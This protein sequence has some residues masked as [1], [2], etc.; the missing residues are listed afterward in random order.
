MSYNIDEWK[1]YACTL[2]I[3]I[4]TLEET[5]DE[6]DFSRPGPD[7]GVLIVAQTTAE[8]GEI[9]GTLRNGIVTIDTIIHVSEGSGS[10]IDDLEELLTSTKGTYRAVLIWEGGDGISLLKVDDGVVSNETLDIVTVVQ[11]WEARR[12]VTKGEIEV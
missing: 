4:D 12:K 10:S 8:N 1:Q 6:I 11:E 3:D 2:T 7:G 9:V 5:Y